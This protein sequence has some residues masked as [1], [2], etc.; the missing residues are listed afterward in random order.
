MNFPEKTILR[1]GRRGFTL[2]ELLV[3]IAI[4]AIL[5]A[6]LLPALA[7]SK[8]TAKR[9]VCKSNMR[10]CT[11]G[12]LMYASEFNENFPDSMFP[13]G[14]YHASWL[15]EPIFNY[16]SYTLKISTNAY[17]C[18]DKNRDA[19]WMKYNANPAWGMWRMG[20]YSLWH[21][22]T[23]A[24]PTPRGVDYGVTVQNP[25]DSPQK[26]TDVTPY[27][28]LMGDIIERNT[29]LVAGVPYA[30]STPHS[31]GGPRVGPPNQQIEPTAIGSEGGNIGLIDGSITWRK[32][33]DMR[34]HY[35]RWNP[36]G[37][38]TPPYTGDTT[39]A[40]YW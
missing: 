39:L 29:D 27:T 7:K 22:P 38:T 23:K 8:E 19:S 15:A 18:P 20:F 34:P 1:N 5:A 30:T 25:W 21:Q 31:R 16:F 6:M 12:A 13:Q 3:V 14:P 40:G 9:T 36:G 33:S 10:Q 4:I 28:Y 37:N 11:L 24:D 32:Q 35:L 17:G 2:I 26:T